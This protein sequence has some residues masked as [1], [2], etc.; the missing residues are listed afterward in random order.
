MEAEAEELAQIRTDLESG[1]KQIEIKEESPDGTA[2]P[3]FKS[4]VLALFDKLLSKPIGY[5]LVTEVLYGP[6]K[7][8]IVPNFEANNFG[9]GVVG[10]KIPQNN[11]DNP[12]LER[13][14]G[15]AGAGSDVILS[16]DPNLNDE[17]S[18]VYDINAQSI[19]HPF[20][21]ILA[22]EL[23]HARN[24]AQ[25]RGKT[26]RST[27]HLPPFQ[28]LDYTDLEELET[29]RLGNRSLDPDPTSRITENVIR[30][31]HCLAERHLYASPSW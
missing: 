7:T 22:H 25:G 21:I 18:A 31:E 5:R 17:D 19:P 4:G 6:K 30:C 29:V 23:I 2:F 10:A 28:R 20:F 14:D 26:G 8:E 3:G 12:H 27:T 13:A 15:T 24:Y 1:S 16:L 9:G 11:S